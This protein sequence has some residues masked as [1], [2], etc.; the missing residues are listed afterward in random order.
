MEEKEAEVSDKLSA[1][2]EKVKIESGIECDYQVTVG[3]IFTEIGNMADD[4]NASLVVMGTH[5]VKGMQHIM[6][7]K[8]LKVIINSNR[9]FVIVQKKPIS[10]DGFKNIVLPIDFSKETKQKVFW[11]KELALK[12]N[13]NF[14]ILAEHESDE[15]AAKAVKNNL[16]YAE[17]YLKDATSTIEIRHSEKGKDFEKETIKFA[18]EVNADLI[19]IMTNQSKDLKEYVVGAY[20]RNII[21][22]EDQFPVMTLNPVDYSKA[23][24]GH[25][26][27][28]SNY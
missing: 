5:G 14:Y 13:S 27:N 25:L 26:F 4:I 9:P 7:S 21:A 6:G 2:A 8:A 12:F 11:A 1:I 23:V 18:R 20:E 3:S 17:N 16:A 19:V 10:K 22:N 24:S 28:F 15:Y